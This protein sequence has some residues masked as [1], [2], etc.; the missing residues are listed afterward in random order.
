MMRTTWL[1][2]ARWWK[3]LFGYA[4]LNVLWIGFSL[5]IIGGPPALAAMYHLAAYD[6]VG[7]YADRRAFFGAMKQLFVPAWRWGLLQAAVYGVGGFNLLYY[8][9]A[10]GFMIDVLRVGWIIGLAVWTVLNLFFW[11]FYMQQDDRRIA[12]TYRNVLVFVT[13]QPGL[14]LGVALLSV[15]IV[16]VAVATVMVFAFAVLP[17]LA[18]LATFAVIGA[19][20]PHRQHAALQA[21]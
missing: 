15:V 5:T 18:L 12:T 1:A 16:A 8:A 19:L 14:T 7:D 20:E 4:I 9:A 6:A 2:V 17:L 10:N 21:H 13:V 11:P 3:N